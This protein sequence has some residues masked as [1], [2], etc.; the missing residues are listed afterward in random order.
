MVLPLHAAVVGTNTPAASLTMERVMKLQAAER[1]PWINYL[2][3]SEVTKA[4]DKFAL[5]QERKG[6]PAIPP[7]PKQGFSG[8]AMDLHRGLAYYR[9]EEAR[10]TGDIIVSFQ[11]PSG[12]W[13]KNL[14]MDAPR[15][16][17]QIYA[18]A[19]LP[20]TPQP[21]GDFDLP[22]DETWHYIATLDNDATNTELHFLAELSA[23]LPGHEGDKYRTSALKGYEYLLQ[24]QYPNGGWPQVYPLEGGYHDAI[25]F[26][27]NAVE[28]SAATLQMV[29]DG[30]RVTSGADEEDIAAA[31][32]MAER[33][34]RT[35]EEPKESVEDYTFVPAAM[36]ER[37]KAAVA[38]ALEC[39]L[40]AQVRLPAPDGKGTVLTVWAQQVDPLTLEPVSARNYE[41]PALS[42]GESADMMEYLMGIEHPSPQVVRAVDA[43]A[44]WFQSK[45]IMGYTWSGGRG[46]PGGRAL[47]AEP[48][49]GPLWARYYS[50]TTG[51]PIFGDRDKTIHDDVMEISPERRNGYAWYGAGPA[52]ALR[53]YAAWLSKHHGPVIIVQ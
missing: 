42:S 52:K 20:P 41:M 24:S 27:D 5:A 48:G 53:E 3:L 8:R 25:T 49:A 28:E 4:A 18:T 12:G 2:K 13:S 40:K 22:K 23:A 45:A 44:K 35:Y 9:S 30:K 11:T 39:I 50:L 29:A 38:K 26:N 34:G 14:A 46:T 16:R 21:A 7:L 6:L 36:R 32:M 33:A 17:G 15:E 43:A 10:R 31:K 47:R 37:A 1:A 51:K 19:N